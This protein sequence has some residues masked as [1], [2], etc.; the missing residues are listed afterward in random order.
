MKLNDKPSRMTRRWLE[1]WAD[2]MAKKADVQDPYW[3][4]HNAGGEQQTFCFECGEKRRMELLKKFRNDP[5]TLRLLD[6][7][8]G[9]WSLDSDSCEHCATCGRL[10][11]YSLTDYGAESEW[12]HF[13][14]SEI[15]LASPEVAYHIQGIILN[16]L[17]LTG[18]SRVKTFGREPRPAEKAK[19]ESDSQILGNNN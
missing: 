13:R 17:K 10:L 16:G 18:L 5:E 3:F 11:A 14:E 15:N 8:D 4:I 1:R 2:R 12:D 9:G 6:S 7:L 19:T